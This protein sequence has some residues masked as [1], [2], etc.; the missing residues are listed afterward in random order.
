MRN[1]TLGQLGRYV[2]A[3]LVGAAAGLA[4]GAVYAAVWGVTHWTVSGK[5]LSSAAAPWLLA[6]GAALGLL[7]GLGWVASLGQTQAPVEPV[8]RRRA[9]AVP[10]G[11]SRI[12]GPAALRRLRG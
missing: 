6:V 7:T 4:G 2:R 8:G 11:L 12:G 10:A 3:A 9:P 1:G 5:A